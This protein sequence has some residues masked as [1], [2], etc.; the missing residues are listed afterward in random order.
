MIRLLIDEN[1]DQR[2]V[3]ALRLR[4]PQINYVTVQQVGLRGVSDPDLLTF[5]AS[6]NRIIVTHDVNTMPRHASHRMRQA[7]P[8]TGVIVVPEG[9]EIGPAVYD[10]EII[11]E[12]AAAGDLLNQIQYLPL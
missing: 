7:R 6:E 1:F 4:V 11:V 3:R 12:C 9:L 2:I 8:M 10:L 5:A